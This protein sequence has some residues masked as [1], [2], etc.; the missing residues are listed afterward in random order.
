MR[1][2]PLK[3]SILSE[4]SFGIGALPGKM[5]LTRAEELATVRG[6]WLHQ[7]F[8]SDFE[9]VRQ[10]VTKAAAK[11]VCASWSSP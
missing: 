7:V 6:G 10:Q 11:N 2:N 5:V 9:A 3:D 4:Y 8:A 1:R